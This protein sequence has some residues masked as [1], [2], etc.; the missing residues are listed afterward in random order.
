MA[1]S[2]TPVMESARFQALDVLRGCA[3]LG[4]LLINI[5]SF[6]M[7]A[8]AS[9]NPMALGEPSARDFAIW[10]ASHVLADQ[11]FMTIFSLLFGAGVLLMSTRAGEQA[12]RLHYRRMSWL[13][14][15]GL[16]HA[17]LLWDGDILAL[18]A[19][20]GFFIYPARKMSNRGLLTAGVAL[21]AVGSL[22]SI[23]LGWALGNAP[24]EAIE[25]WNE[26]WR[27]PA[28]YVTKEIAALRGG[29]LTQLPWRAREA[30]DFHSF[31]I[32]WWGAWRVGG[33]MLAG[34]AL[35]RAGV[36]TGERPA[37]FYRNLGL[38]GM[39]IGVPLVTVGLVRNN[40][41][42]WNVVDG[43]F[44]AS[45]WNYWGSVAIA[46]GWMGWILL[47]WKSGQARWLVLRFAAVGRMAFTC[48]IAE[49]VLC[50]MLFYGHGFGLFG[51]VDRLGQLGV[52][53]GVWVV[54]LVGA[55]WWLKHFR[56]G[57][58]EWLWR[59][60]TY[61]QVAPIVEAVKSSN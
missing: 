60:L 32:L 6:A 37:S 15:F 42:G 19:L 36:V 58:L 46:L 47:F 2:P 40:A 33:L 25:T 54:L 31:D 7:P 51:R 59:T 26:S 41:T 45:Q 28:A 61:G 13:L 52:T 4:I 9:S 34:M 17:Y 23:L 29:W 14:V 11:K 39:A 12:A 30:W 27:P 21:V 44:L 57:P 8:A 50:T 1:A 3:V 24:R 10:I 16:L 22:V 18:Y 20:C 49:T 48:Y 55:P 38:A 53:L 56:F 35:L 43:F 5:Q